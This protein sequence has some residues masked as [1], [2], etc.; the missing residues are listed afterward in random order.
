MALPAPVAQ[1]KFGQLSQDQQ[2]A[3]LAFFGQKDEPIPTQ[4]NFLGSALHYAGN[5]IKAAVA[6]PFKALNEVSDFMTRLYRTGA[7]AVDQKVDLAQAFQIA[8]DKG[9]S[10]FSPGRIQDA[11]QKFGS[12]RIDVA[13]QVA[14]GKTLDQIIASGTDAQKLVAANAAQ[15]KDNLFQD[16]LDAVNASKYS[17]GRQLA[18]LLLPGSLEGSGV[19]Y[20]G[21]SGIGDA[22]YRVFAD[23]TLALGKAK[24]AYDAG[25]WLIFNLL[26]K[27]KYSYGRSLLNTVGNEANINRVFDNNGV[28]NFFDE[29]GK[30][31]ESLRTARKSADPLAGT[32]ARDALKRLAP[33]FG[34]AAL[35]EFINA[36]VKDADTAKN[37]LL[38]FAGNKAI[39]AGQAARKV[40]LVPKLDAARKARMAILTGANKVINIDKAGR[41]II[42]TLYGSAPTA[43]DIIQGLGARQGEIAQLEARQGRLITGKVR[44]GSIRLNLKQINGKMDRFA[45]K[46]ETIPFFKDGYFDVMS[47]DAPDKV[48]QMASLG[49]TKYHAKVISEVF[50][51]G[52]EGQRKQIFQGL[53][54]T[55]S[56]IRG[57]TKSIEGKAFNDAFNALEQRY[58]SD[59]VVEKLDDLGQ[60]VREVVNPADFNGQQMAIHGW[61][62]SSAMAVPSLADLDRLAVRT[63]LFG[64]LLGLSHQRAAEN[65]TSNWSLAT[66]AGP[67]FPVRNAGED[68]MMHLAAGDSGW[69]IAKG[70]VLS[71]QFRK[72]REAQFGLTKEHYALADEIKSLKA[73]GASAEQ[74]A[75]KRAELVNLVPKQR[76]T[77]GKLFESN[78]GIINKIVYKKDVAEFRAKFAEAGGDIE[79]VRQV[80][81]EGLIRSKVASKFL[82]EN[83]K[84]FIEELAAHGNMDDFLREFAEGSKNALRGGDQFMAATNDVKKFG[85]MRAIEIDGVKWKQASGSK[86]EDVNPVANDGARRTW[87]MK[88]GSHVHDELDSIVVKNLKDKQKAIN[89]LKTYLDNNPQIQNRFRLYSPDVGGNTALHAERVYADVL[90]TFSK[91][92]GTLNEELWSKVRKLDKNG[93]PVL[94]TQT[95]GLD[96]LPT[97]GDVTLHPKFISGPT[98]V[99]VTEGQGFGATIRER[100]WE[101]HGEANA[102]MSREGIGVDSYLQIRKEMQESG[103]EKRII[104]Q[105]TAGLTGEDLIKAEAKAKAEII[106]Q[107]QEMSI[108]RVLQYVDN[109][110]V[111]SQLAMSARNFARFYR[112]TEDFYRR[113]YRTVRYN[114]E[115]LTRASLTYE[116]IAH[117][118][119]VQTDDNGDQYFFYPGLAPVYKVMNKVMR[120]F[121]VKDAF[122]TPMPLEF[123]AKLK[124]ITPSLNP[125][126]LFPTFAGPLAA[127]PI[128]MIGNVIPQVK[129][130]EQY[131]LGTYGEDQPMIQAALPGHVNRILSLL[132]TNERNSQYASAFRKAAT[133]LE[134][135]GHGI[136]EKIDPNTGQIIPPTAGEIAAYQTKLQA[137]TMTVLALRFGF[138]FFAPASPSLTLKSDMAQW[139]RDN[140]RTS[141]KQVFNQLIQQYKG[142]INKATQEWIKLF[143][144]QMPYTISESEKNT[145]AVVRAVEQSG[146]WIQKNQSTLTKYPQGAAFLIP[147]EGNFDFNAYKLMTKSGL[148]ESKTLTDFLR[149]V[150]TAKD[151]Q[152][153]YAQKDLYDQQLKNTYND[154]AKQALRAQWQTYKEQTVGTN[155]LLAEQLSQGSQAAFK[156]L[157]AYQDLQKMLSDNTITTQ[158]QTRAVLKQMSDAYNQYMNARDMVYGNST[159]ASNYKELLKNN[160]K[161]Q[162]Q[163]MAQGNANAQSAYDVLFARMI[164]D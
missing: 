96:D 37:F 128:K 30:G 145:V 78:L 129:Q 131:F 44:D 72:L 23:P 98:L 138:G 70:R 6:T 45:R 79:K 42:E 89:E 63:G 28:R 160:I 55:V 67:R 27:E 53:W 112:A 134:A 146:N 111:R 5:A 11:K 115:A 46:F 57:V 148:K 87:M 74:I 110:Q 49:T 77:F 13:M 83:D 8:N 71:T 12:D 114:P 95:F 91:Y 31:L 66:L 153:Y 52:N 158:P 18:N 80:M 105:R 116:G 33:E 24:K 103:L 135:S 101:A 25:D 107:A 3:H 113:V 47:S 85:T 15:N 60:V 40:P 10:V 122:Q 86:F 21:I 150:Q 154:A 32:A 142:D 69:G 68:L 124:M 36:G 14:A 125:D 73:A 19:L 38:N 26:G 22:A 123:G 102:R 140:Q 121:G 4:R 50:A 157:A 106:Q 88:I 161:V 29:F 151:V 126:S 120:V 82:N 137:S 164:G 54:N 34:P 17:P 152:Q 16:A 65:L 100:L 9:D 51:S 149:Q 35:D 97:K 64:R 133:Y 93:N 59:I 84:R 92:D 62:V 20:K 61:Q 109:P 76:D 163:Q 141:Y 7:I 58:A 139:V 43:D 118:G 162:L 143:P 136:P 132:D 1:Q 144:D 147:Q 99:P 108:S 39:F 90:N 81:A 117:S 56:E 155:P 130:L 127:I 94:S 104:E 2:N 75:A 41:S 119:F 159:T 156:R 48:Y